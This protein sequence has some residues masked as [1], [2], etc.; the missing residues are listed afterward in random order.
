MAN[1]VFQ[2]IKSSMNRGITTI[3]VKTSSSLEKTKIKTHIDSLNKEIEK[4]T[5]HIGEKAYAIWSNGKDDYSELNGLF[6]SIKQKTQEI[7]QLNEELSSIDERDS[8]ILGNAK[9]DYQAGQQEQESNKGVFC[10]QC[11]AFYET[12]VKFCKQCGN[13]IIK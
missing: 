5:Y 12:P 10:S 13:Q 1:D 11:G 4:C 7:E 2:K 8:Q 3:S 9:T 6:E